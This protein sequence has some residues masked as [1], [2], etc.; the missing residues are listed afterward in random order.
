MA[1]LTLAPF[2]L[3]PVRRLDGSA[4]NYQQ[5][6]YYVK[7]A[8]ATSLGFG[9]PVLTLT[10]G[11]NTGYVGAYTAG[12]THIL[13]V[14]AGLCGYFD[15]NFQQ[16]QNRPGYT[17]AVTPPTGQDVPVWII[18]DPQAVFV[19]Q[20]GTTSANNPGTVA[21]RGGNIDMVIGTPTTAGYSTSYLDSNSYNNTT[22][23]LP[24]RI[25]GISQE[26]FPGFDPTQNTPTSQPTNNYLEVVF[27]TSEF[28]TATGI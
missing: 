21:M 17:S 9:D 12:S 2:G 23:T 7:N 14:F 20:L 1:T 26:F 22:A 13:G 5:N 18:D 25:V 4:P 8:Y 28:R 10:G 11:S 16:W 15:T 24:L 3:R 6:V 27:N 19:A